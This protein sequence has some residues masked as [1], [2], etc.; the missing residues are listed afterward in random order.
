[1]SYLH[2]QENIQH[3]QTA[4]P[5][6]S[7]LTSEQ[8]AQLRQNEAYKM[9]NKPQFDAVTQPLHSYLV[10]AGAGSGKT[11][12]LVKRIVYAVTELNVRPETIM[13]VTFTNKAAQELKWRVKKALEGVLDYADIEKMH[14]G[15]FHGLSFRLLREKAFSG[16]QSQFV[17]WE[18]DEIIDKLAELLRDGYNALEPLSKKFAR[19]Y[20]RVQEQFIHARAMV[21]QFDIEKEQTGKVLDE[22]ACA[23]AKTKLNRWSS[24]K[25]VIEAILKCLEGKK[26][27]KFNE[28]GDK[29]N[30]AG[31]WA[32]IAAF[33][34]AGY[35]AQNIKFAE[36]YE[37]KLQTEEVPELAAV[38][39]SFMF[40]LDTS[41]KNAVSNEL[42]EIYK[43]L[44]LEIFREYQDYADDNNLLDFSD[45]INK[46]VFKIEN[47]DELRQAIANH[48]HLIMVDEFQDTN[49]MQYRWLQLLTN[50]RTSV[51]IV[52][53]DDQ[54]I[55]AWRGAHPEYMQYFLYDFSLP[56]SSEKPSAK[57]FQKRKS[58]IETPLKV[59]KLEQNY[60]STPNILNT[61]NV[62]IKQNK[63]RMDKTLFTKK[64]TENMPIRLAAFD[65]LGAGEERN[66]ESEFVIYD[67]KRLLEAERMKGKDVSYND[68][69]ILY[70]K[71]STGK[72]YQKA[73]LKANI[74]HVV[75]GAFNFYKRKPIKAALNWLD[76]AFNLYN[77]FLFE[78]TFKHIPATKQQ[79]L[80]GEQYKRKGYYAKMIEV[81]KEEKK[82]TQT[83]SLVEALINLTDRFRFE[84]AMINGQS[85]T[86]MGEPV[87]QDYISPF[88]V[89]ESNYSL[90]FFHDNK[91]VKMAE[92]MTDY[93]KMLLDLLKVMDDPNLDYKEY[94]PKLLTACGL[95][96]YYQQRAKEEAEKDNGETE[97]QEDLEWLEILMTQIAEREK[98]P[99]MSNE[100]FIKQCLYEYRLA[101]E[102]E[103][104]NRKE[105][106][107]N[108]M[109]IHASKGLEF[110]YV[111]LVEM[112]NQFPSV[113]RIKQLGGE[114][115]LEDERRLFYV[116]ITR[117]KESLMMT[118]TQTE[119]AGLSLFYN[120]L[121]SNKQCQSYIDDL[122][123]F[124]LTEMKAAYVRAREQGLLN[125][126]LR[127]NEV[128]AHRKQFLEAEQV[129][130]QLVQNSELS[131][132]QGGWWMPM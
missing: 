29:I 109:T 46:V 53:D 18:E 13:A 12:V 76:F 62:V 132:L 66:L 70:R 60:R 68:V 57:V 67:I 123:L 73:L 128:T 59:I 58:L 33:K 24:A 19:L 118:G 40:Y 71:N 52:G 91:K 72:H 25:T 37:F 8:I 39:P 95:L 83:H 27:A 79:N 63:E 102:K 96:P 110:K 120:N 92:Q 81:L 42:P 90:E 32:W 36:E 119:K 77:D 99:T 114:Q 105:A 65:N 48:Y 78:Q 69:A 6:T 129:A 122:G 82:R 87:P 64:Q 107:V 97:A 51:M 14:I 22:N 111:Y 16:D 10:L 100:I 108:L 116:A 93:V 94:T 117:A 101:T 9:L 130:K 89:E 113:F 50:E 74:P 49:K 43:Y 45:L 31:V 80:I 35:N 3:T 84:K 1:M 55:Y 126:P 7:G 2:T 85:E 41:N 23:N 26:T 20:Q 127:S 115:F 124:D 131:A 21:D 104:K 47:D 121:L 17:L 88:A 103:D 75:Y 38:L 61:A 4:Y 112:N 34:E 98:E 28:N 5:F 86:D 15:T 106:A 56:L 11:S 30:L 44:A 54:S 125:E